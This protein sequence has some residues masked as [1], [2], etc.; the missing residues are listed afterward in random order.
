MSQAQSSATCVVVEEEVSFSL[1]QLCQASGAEAD[2]VVILVQ[3]G[4]LTPSGSG[5]QDWQ[6]QG[7]SLKRTLRVI[8]L[9]RD[10]ELGLPGA[11]LVMDL[12]EEI[13]ALRARLQRAGIR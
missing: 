5:P 8:R 12:L 13:E 10:F 2:Q 4:V 7:P 9:A 6:F 3:E 11:A 1:A